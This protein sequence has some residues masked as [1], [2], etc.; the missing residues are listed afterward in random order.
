[1]NV[2]LDSYALLELVSGSQEGNQVRQIITE[3]ATIYTTV[4]NLYEVRYRMT[5]IYSQKDADDTISTLKATANT[6]P[7]TEDVSFEASSIKLKHPKMGAVD[8]HT[9]AAARLHGLKVVTGDRDFPAG[10]DVI[11]L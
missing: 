8:C 11:F 7:I 5:Q 9:L 6:L 1:M 4:L 2:L 10:N 3:S